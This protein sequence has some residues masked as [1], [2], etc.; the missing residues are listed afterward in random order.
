MKDP[1]FCDVTGSRLAAVE[2]G[3]G[4]DQ[5]LYAYRQSK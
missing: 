5:Q 1:R 2:S 3:G 4:D